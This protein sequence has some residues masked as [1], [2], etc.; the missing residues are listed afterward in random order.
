MLIGINE[1]E[2]MP[3]ERLQGLSHL[4]ILNMTHNKLK[5]LEEFPSDMKSLQILDISFNQIARIT[6]TTFQHLENLAELYLYGNWISQVS[7]D[8]FKPLKKLRTLDLSKNY[9]E[10]IPLNAFRPLETQI[11]SL[12]TE[13][14]FFIPLES[15][16]INLGVSFRKSVIVQL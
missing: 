10:H 7:G 6:K 1:L 16:L 3:Q 8:A 11:R 13:G 15:D 4:R 14:R 5:E 12:R 2:L 9:L